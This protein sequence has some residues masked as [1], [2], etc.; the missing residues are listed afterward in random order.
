MGNFW[1]NEEESSNKVVVVIVGVALVWKETTIYEKCS[2]LL[3]S[4]VEKTGVLSRSMLKSLLRV[5]VLDFLT[6][7]NKDTPG[8]ASA[9]RERT[10]Q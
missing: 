1:E 10:A 3:S 4:L 8:A 9:P 2:W 6:K 7:E 5:L